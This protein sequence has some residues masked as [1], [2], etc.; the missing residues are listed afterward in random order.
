[1]LATVLGRLDADLDPAL[2]ADLDRGRDPPAVA[3]L[4]AAEA[5]SSSSSF[6]KSDCMLARFLSHHSRSTFA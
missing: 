5:P 2:D 3:S 4:L 1:M 6:M